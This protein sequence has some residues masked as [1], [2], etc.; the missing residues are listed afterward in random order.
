MNKVEITF[1]L[2]EELLEQARANGVPI[3]D[4]NI[5]KMIEAELVRARAA[6]QGA[7]LEGIENKLAEM[8][9]D[10]D[11]QR[12]IRQIQA[13]FDGTEADGLSDDQ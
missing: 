5:A 4:A 1:N 7:V 3:T 9:A 6:K 12:E 10:P 13:E 2:P 8:A 11:I